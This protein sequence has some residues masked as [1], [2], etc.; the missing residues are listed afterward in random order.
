MWV[1]RPDRTRDFVNH[2]Y[3]DLMGVGC[4]EAHTINRVDRIHPDDR[5]RVILLTISE[6]W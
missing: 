6:L 2:A 4:E 5:A 1:T 3:V